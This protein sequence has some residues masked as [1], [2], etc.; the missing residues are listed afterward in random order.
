MFHDR[1]A[2]GRSIS[3]IL[4][5]LE[6][7]MLAT[8]CYVLAEGEGGE[9]AVIDPAGELKRINRALQEHRLQLR[10]ILL[11]H[12]HPDHVSGAGPLSDAS[13]APVFIHPL[14]AEALASRRN[15]LLGLQAGVRASRPRQVQE[16]SDGQELR[17]DGL[18]MRV[19]HTPGHTPGGVSFYLPDRPPGHL[20]C[21]DLVFAGSIGRTDLRGGSLQALLT[22][23][24]ERL[25]DMPDE[26]VI[27]PG[28][29]PETT[30]GEEKRHNPFLIGLGGRER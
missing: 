24:R 3:L 8:N 9:A 2:T 18:K 12:G 11:T 10:M 15:L 4:Q 13:G 29:G 26:T 7:G 27:H 6:L 5:R 23:V 30:L 19:L 21:G 20:F 16:L 17:L 1:K 25:W 14:D 22:A 28:H